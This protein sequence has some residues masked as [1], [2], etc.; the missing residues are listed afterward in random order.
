MNDFNQFLS[1]I[2]DELK[3][4]NTNY[5][6]SETETTF[7]FFLDINPYPLLKK[8]LTIL[9]DEYGAEYSWKDDCVIIA[10]R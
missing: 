2:F 6:T 3:N 10:E 8:R 1:S 9:F 7:T 5:T 4:F